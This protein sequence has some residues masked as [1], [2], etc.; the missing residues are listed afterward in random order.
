MQLNYSSVNSKRPNKCEIKIETKICIKN[1][2]DANE[3]SFIFK[4]KS[5]VSFYKNALKLL[6]FK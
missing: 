2:G 1:K 4:H 5:H 3:T 6:V